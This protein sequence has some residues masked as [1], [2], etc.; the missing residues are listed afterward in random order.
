MKPIIKF[1]DLKLLLTSLFAFGLIILIGRF[2]SIDLTLKILGG[3]LVYFLG[4]GKQLLPELVEKQINKKCDQVPQ[5]IV[6]QIEFRL[7]Q[8]EKRI[9]KFSQIIFKV[10]A[11]IKVS[12]LDELLEN[13]RLNNKAIAE[14]RHS[15]SDLRSQIEKT[16]KIE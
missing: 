11:A 4:I 14:L 6:T 9:D 5:E 3:V 2:V 15:I 7:D 10:E 16:D 13:E 8:I 12:P 1:F